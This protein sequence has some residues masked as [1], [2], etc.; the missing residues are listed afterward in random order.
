MIFVEK[1]GRFGNFLFQ[2]FVAKC[3]QKKTKHNI[4]VFSKNENIYSFNSKKNIDRIVKGY[5]SLPKFSKFLNLWK[6]KFLYVNDS[7]YKDIL[8]SDYLIKDKIVYIDGFFQDISIIDSNK[9]LLSEII[10]T[11]ENIFTNNSLIADLTIHIRHLHHEL[12]TLDTNP[13]Y[14]DQPDINYYINI[15]NTLNPKSIKI[16]CSSQKNKN[17]IRIKDVYKDKVFHDLKDDIYDFFNILKSKNLIISNSSFSFWASILSEAKNIYV[18]NIGIIKKIFGN[19][20][21]NFKK[22]FI[23]EQ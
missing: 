3:I 16:I 1:K 2:I 21:F 17:L 22:N 6:K 4:F 18:P 11:E 14:Q 19:K 13:N 8:S 12:G 15:I 5:V 10:K 7:N 23:Y 20:K 9:D